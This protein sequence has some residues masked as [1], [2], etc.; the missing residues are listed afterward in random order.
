M[1]VPFVDL[2]RQ[3]EGL[4]AEFDAAFHS[5]V[6]RAAY[7]MGPELAQFEEAFAH[8]CGCDHAIGVSSGTDA[9]KLALLAA[10][11]QPGTTSSSRPT[12]SSPPP[13]P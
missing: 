12:R 6:E 13:R 9:V 1:R 10:G 8:F 11:V 3:A 7:T 2:K 5:V 4:R